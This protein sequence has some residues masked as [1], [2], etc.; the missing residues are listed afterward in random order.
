MF[1]VLNHRGRGFEEFRVY[2]V[3]NLGLRIGVRGLG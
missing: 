2:K 3:S 1:F